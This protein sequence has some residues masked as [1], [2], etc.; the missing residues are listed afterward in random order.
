MEKIFCLLIFSL[1]LSLNLFPQDWEKKESGF[2]KQDNNIFYMVDSLIKEKDRND[3]IA[4]TKEYIKRDLELLQETDF[5][6]P[7]V[8]SSLHSRGEMHKLS[9]KRTSGF[10]IFKDSVGRFNLVVVVYDRNHF[11]LNRELMKVIVHSRWGKQDDNQL[12][13]LKEGLATYANPEAD[14]CDG[15]S[16]EE[17]YVYLIQNEKLIDLEQFSRDGTNAEYK[18]ARIQSAYTVE[19]LLDKHGIDKLKQLWKD[20]MDDFEKIYGSSFNVLITDINKY[21]REKYTEPVLVSREIFSKDCIEPQ[22]DD[23]LPAFKPFL[24]SSPKLDEMVTKDFGNLKLTVDSAMSIA[25]R[26]DA[27]K[28]AREYI[29]QNL[30][31]MNEKE[32][33][34]SV[35]IYLSSDKQ[36][37]AELAGQS[38]NGLFRI[39]DEGF[40]EN[41]V[42]GVYQQSYNPL[43]HELMHA[44]SFILWGENTLNWLSEGL[45][46][47]S[48]PQSCGCDGRTIEER[49]VFFLQSGKLLGADELIDFPDME[50]KPRIHIA[51]NQSAYIVGVLLQR[52]GIEK[53]KALWQSNGMDDFEKIYGISFEKTISDIN[54]ELSEKYPEPIEFDWERFQKSCTE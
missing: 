42:F 11:S 5:S 2:F 6:E 44:V 39:K 25:Q 9:G 33:N 26:N 53:I 16:V 27:I 45:A 30:E 54:S 10:S 14:G 15:L 35:H 40:T 4:T 52:Y 23:W 24:H 49:N 13:W 1:F 8:I 19:Y 17:K 12:I 18:A 7:L 37:I 3:I 51:Y 47:Y 50:E 48:D 28:K 20:G 21:L 32:F 41:M 43:K 38:C 46:T 34:D 29:T 36:K 31:L 22:P